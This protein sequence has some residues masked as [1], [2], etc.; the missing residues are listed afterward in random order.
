MDVILP[1]VATSTNEYLELKIALRS[2][3][4]CSD[5]GKVYIVTT[6]YIPWI[7]N[8]VIVPIDDPVKDNKDKNLIRKIQLTLQKYPEITDFVLWMD[9]F[10]ITQPMSLNDIP[11]VYNNRGLD[12]LSKLPVRT[13]WQERLLW[14]LKIFKFVGK[15]TDYNWDSHVPM[16]FNSEKVLK[17]LEM[18]DYMSSGANFTLFTLLANLCDKVKANGVLQDVVKF[19]CEGPVN[20]PIDWSKLFVGFNDKSFNAGLKTQLIEHF[21]EKSKYEASVLTVTD[22]VSAFVT[23][24]TS[25]DRLFELMLNSKKR[26]ITFPWDDV[27]KNTL[28]GSNMS[29]IPYNGPALNVINMFNLSKLMSKYCIIY[30]GKHQY[31]DTYISDCLTDSADSL[32]VSYDPKNMSGIVNNS[33]VSATDVLKLANITDL[34]E[35]ML[36]L[37]DLSRPSV[38]IKDEPERL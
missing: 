21:T 38:I 27:S 13:K 7:Q 25:T 29:C 3:S 30:D 35:F 32:A 4:Q 31:N 18:M 26:I 36:Q 11:D 8:A 20:L 34:N 2:L 10:V 28:V 37:A 12:L 5:V 19:T 14:T 33:L 22:T 15:S 6:G 23:N 16:R 9:D 24:C 1:L 17:G